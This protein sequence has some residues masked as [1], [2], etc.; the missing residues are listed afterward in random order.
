MQSSLQ[1]Q[2]LPSHSRRRSRNGFTLIELLVVIAIISVL[3]ALLLPAVQKARESARR[4]ECKNNLK[5]I[6]LASHNYHIEQRSF[7]SGFIFAAGEDVQLG[8]SDGTPVFPEPFR[9]Q[10]KKRNITVNAWLMVPAWSWQAF[11]LS[12]M[13]A[14]TANA[15]FDVEKSIPDNLIAV[16][17][18]IKPYTCPSASFPSIRPI[19]VTPLISRGPGVAY[20]SYRG[21]LGTSQSNG[22]FYENSSVRFRDV[23]D[24]QTQTVLFGESLFGFWGDGLSCCARARFDLDSNGVPIRPILDEYYV[25]TND[26]SIQFFGFGSWH[27]DVMHVAMVDG[28]VQSLSKSVNAIVFAALVTRNG[29]ERINDGDF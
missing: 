10:Q 2:T 14:Q 25:D 12:E 6:A 8:R 4:A 29:N 21:N 9:Y 1:N 20:S 5:N 28:S 3:I 23:T 27:G 19:P 15:S 11:L 22:M 26:P 13:D 16:Q 24:G 17:V 18:G 7:P